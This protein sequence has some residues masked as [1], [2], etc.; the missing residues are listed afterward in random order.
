[1]PGHRPT[2]F[3]HV[4]AEPYETCKGPV[5]AEEIVTQGPVSEEGARSFVYV[6]ATPDTRQSA[7]GAGI[8]GL[9]MGLRL[10]Q[11]S[12]SGGLDILGWQ[13]CSI[14]EF[15]YPG[16]P[17]PGTGTTLTWTT[18]LCRERDLV[19][20]GVMEVAAHAPSVLSI[21]GYLTTGVAKV[22]DC[23]G[24]EIVLDGRYLGWVSFGGATWNS[25]M[26]GCNPLLRPCAENVVPVRATTWGRIKAN[27]GR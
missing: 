2:I 9:Q 26:G 3:L 19:V 1:V 23:D 22:A 10:H 27:Y 5:H 6:L 14:L 16:W 7:A 25:Q 24:A 13:P 15:P 8:T 17:A 20:A 4:A 18:E 11:Q 12:G 21:M